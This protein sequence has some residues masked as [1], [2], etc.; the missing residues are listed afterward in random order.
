MDQ[1]VIDDKHPPLLVKLAQRRVLRRYW[2]N[3]NRNQSGVGGNNR[4]QGR[5]NR[6]GRGR[7]GNNKRRYQQ[8]SNRQQQQRMGGQQ[9]AQYQQR[10]QP[11]QGGQPYF[12]AA[13]YNDAYAMAPQYPQAA[14]TQNMHM[15]PAMN[16]PQNPANPSGVGGWE[17]H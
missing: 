8:K 6:G 3:Q 2:N 1:Y 13:M 17:Q 11:N 4:G 12:P 9:K 14:Y 15:A 16:P 7:G 10:R 5:G